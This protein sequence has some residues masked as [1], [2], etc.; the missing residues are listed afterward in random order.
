MKK[1]P[2]KSCR[3]WKE[4]YRRADPTS[5][6]VS[7]NV[8]QGRYS[9]SDFEWVVGEYRDVNG[10]RESREVREPSKPMYFHDAPDMIVMMKIVSLAANELFPRLLKHDGRKDASGPQDMP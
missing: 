7:I 4:F 8:G 9:W 3:A 6:R 5:V 2:S 10:V 1:K